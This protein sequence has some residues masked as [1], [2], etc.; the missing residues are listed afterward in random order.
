MKNNEMQILYEPQPEWGGNWTLKKLDAFAKYV[1][2]YLNIMKSHSYWKT[3][4]FDGFAGSGDRKMKCNSLLYKQLFLD[5][6]ETHRYKGAAERVLTL[7]D[8]L[9]FD[10]Y[11]FI[12]TNTVS[13][14]KL[15]QKLRHIKTE[16]KSQLQYRAG[17]C[18]QNLIE[19]ANA[20]KKNPKR[21][22]SLVLLDPFGMQI[23]WE[24]IS[25]LRDTRTDIWILVPT[26]VV[27][28]RLLDRNG[29][30]KHSVRLQ[31]F[32]GLTED[33]IRDYFYKKE[34]I[35]TLFGEQELVQKIRKPIERIAELY[36]RQLKTSW[37][38][39]TEEPLRLDN[40][41]GV[42]IFHF[43]FASNNVNALKIAKQIIKNV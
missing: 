2:A 8:K 4:Y 36:I 35:K 20:M 17:D 37:K 25:E 42:P 38:Y 41:K 27:V 11:Y 15:K 10:F 43:V 7:P 18:N 24:S 14:Q 31:S 26:G 13:L 23:K 29:E 33:E 40:K 28:N 19:L 6:E 39:V 9:A 22:A 12:D 30:L 16:P 21:F 5:E 3:I 34:T 32:F 1:S